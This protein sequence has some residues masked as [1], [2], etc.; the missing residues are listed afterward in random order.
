VKKPPRFRHEQGSEDALKLALRA[1]AL[2]ND[3][4]TPART[5]RLFAAALA[6]IEY[7]EH[8]ERKSAIG[9]SRAEVIAYYELM[10]ASGKGPTEAAEDTAKFFGFNDVSSVWKKVGLHGE[11]YRLP[12][13]R[14]DF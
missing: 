10:I 9:G 13:P 11:K 1:A 5:K 3:L 4:D 14:L 8:P 12:R 6:Y 7:L 2:A